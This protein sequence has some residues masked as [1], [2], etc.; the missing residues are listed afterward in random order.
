[1]LL[2]ELLDDVPRE[3]P[4][5]VEVKSQGAILVWHGRPPLRCA[6]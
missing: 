3:L 2:E 5:Q 1:M 6:G 4:V